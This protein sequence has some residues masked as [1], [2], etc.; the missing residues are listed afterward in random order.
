[1]IKIGL[2]LQNDHFGGVNL[3][4]HFQKYAPKI[5]SIKQQYCSWEFLPQT[6]R[7]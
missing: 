4:S 6:I 5:E 7:H 2:P 1:M 3:K